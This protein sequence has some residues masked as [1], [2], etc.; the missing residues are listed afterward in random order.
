MNHQEEIKE[1]LKR[2]LASSQRDQ[3]LSLLTL[4]LHKLTIASRFVYSERHN[5]P[6]S[7]EK[8]YT[9][10]ELQHRVAGRMMRILDRDLTSDE[11]FVDSLFAVARQGDCLN[12]LLLAITDTLALP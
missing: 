12:G 11:L 5:D 10:N 1:H 7:I 3:K 9:L 6:A 2:V 8:L 4:L